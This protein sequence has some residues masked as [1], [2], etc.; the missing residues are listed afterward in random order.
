MARATSVTAIGL[1]W[2]LIVVLDVAVS[3]LASVRVT[4]TV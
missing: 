3:P 1:A 4:V 2:T